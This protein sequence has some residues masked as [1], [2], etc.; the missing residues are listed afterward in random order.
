MHLITLV[1]RSKSQLQ[2]MSAKEQ[3]NTLHR[4]SYD[5]EAE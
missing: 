4:I 2:H 3:L 5:D 1:Q